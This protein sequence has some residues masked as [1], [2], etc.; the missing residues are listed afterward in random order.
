[1]YLVGHCHGLSA[2]FWQKA[3]RKL[4][5]VGRP[6]IL[7]ICKLRCSPYNENCIFPPSQAPSIEAPKAPSIEA[8]RTEAGV[9]FLVIGQPSPSSPAIGLGER[10]NLTSGVLGRGSAEIGLVRFNPL[11]VTFSPNVFGNRGGGVKLPA[12]FDYTACI[13]NILTVSYYYCC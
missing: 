6:C 2:Q 11:S 3:Q 7:Y 10:Y 12:T 1:M 8:R 9:K 4:C 13:F 5:R